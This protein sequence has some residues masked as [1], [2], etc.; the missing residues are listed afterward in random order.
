MKT[1]R[2]YLIAIL[3][4]LVVSIGYLFLQNKHAFVDR[5]NLVLI[6]LLDKQIDQEKTKAFAFAYSLSENETLQ[7]AIEN[8]DTAKGYG[9]L[10]RYMKTLEAFSG[11][12]IRTQIVTRDFVIFARSWDNRD[13]GLNVA[14]YRP[15]LQEMLKSGKPHLSFEAARRLVLI[16]SI[17]IV[18]AKE[19]IGFV[20]VIE[21]FDAI[22]SFF[23]H[24]DID[25]LVL[26]DDRYEQQSILLRENPRIGHM[27]VANDNANVHHIDTLR[28]RN[29]DTLLRRG[30]LESEKS[31]Y[32]SRAILNTDG[33]NI[34]AFVLSLSKKKLKLF[35][36]FEE[37]LDTF[38]TYARKDLY[39]ASIDTDPSMRLYEDAGTKELLL[40]KNCAH[41][42]DKAL[43]RQKLHVALKR[44]SKEELIALLLD[45]NTHRKSRG[46]IK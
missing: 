32:F 19:I 24:Y 43:I 22:A 36:A 25:L 23:S 10:R 35:N 8:N 46:I 44:Y 18:K 27:I 11:A 21:K 13:A 30:M 7:E 17:P 20:E 12:R 3:L 2:L 28:K 45:A 29:I 39:Y 38:F 9:I 42:E 6:H 4:L 16:A 34:G 40:L 5:V 33:E 31:F 14:R 37:E 15:D 41:D 26:L 1:Y